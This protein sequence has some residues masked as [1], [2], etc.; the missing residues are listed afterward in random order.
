MN[1][2]DSRL[3]DTLEIEWQVV[4]VP[5]PVRGDFIS[6]RW[7]VSRFRKEARCQGES[8]AQT[9]GAAHPSEPP[10]IDA[11]KGGV[12]SAAACANTACLPGRRV[13]KKHPRVCVPHDVPALGAAARTLRS[14]QRSSFF[15]RPLGHLRGV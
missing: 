10:P 11:A 7:P 6:H 9:N 5:L 13:P 4:R 12:N 14:R 3:H 2:T 15:H 8:K 1:M